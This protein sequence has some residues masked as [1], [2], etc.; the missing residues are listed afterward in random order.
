MQSAHYLLRIHLNHTLEN[1]T[2]LESVH[3]ASK[4]I[5]KYNIGARNLPSPREGIRYSPGVLVK[6]YRAPLNAT[7]M[8]STKPS[9]NTTKEQ[10]AQY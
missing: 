4:K 1:L 5:P 10:K 7:L 3:G 9:V 6:L 2:V 8:L